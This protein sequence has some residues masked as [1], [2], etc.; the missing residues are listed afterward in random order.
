MITRNDGS[1][2]DARTKVPTHTQY[3]K[4]RP[5][6]HHEIHADPRTLG[7]RTRRIGPGSSAMM[8]SLKCEQ[9]AMYEQESKSNEAYQSSNCEKL[10]SLYSPDRSHICLRN[11]NPKGARDYSNLNT[12]RATRLHDELHDSPH[13]RKGRQRLVRL[14]Y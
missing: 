3:Q 2:C 6:T 4:R 1:N 11:T 5:T 13:G 7:A 8:Q 14:F 12:A 10:A 9:S